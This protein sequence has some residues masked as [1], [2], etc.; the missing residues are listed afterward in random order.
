LR[1]SVESEELGPRQNVALHCAL[2]IFLGCL[3]FQVHQSEKLEGVTG[4]RAKLWARTAVAKLPEV[5]QSLARTIDEFVSPCH[6]FWK[7]ARGGRHVVNDPVDRTP[8]T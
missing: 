8:G 5:I 3:R 4:G 6:G 1:T 2:D 7:L